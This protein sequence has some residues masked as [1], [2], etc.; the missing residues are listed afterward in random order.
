[1]YLVTILIY[2]PTLCSGISGNT[3]W[4]IPRYPTPQNENAH[5]IL[6]DNARYLVT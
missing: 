3:Q 1:M 2:S 5:G 4:H 6:I